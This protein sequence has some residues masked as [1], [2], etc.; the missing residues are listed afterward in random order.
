MFSWVN[1][2]GY[3]QG[4]FWA[5]LV[6]LVSSLNDVF[7][8][9]VGRLDGMQIAFMRFAISSLFLVPV[10]FIFNKSSFKTNRFGFHMVRA[11]FIYAAIVCW[12]MGVG[13]FSTPL[14]IASTLAQTTALFVLPMAFIFL[15]ERVS[16]QCS[17]ATIAGFIGIA[18]T[19]QPDSDMFSMSLFKDLNV[20]ALLLVG[21]AVLFAASD[22]FNKI[23]VDNESTLTMMFYI[24]AGAA[25]IGLYPAIQVWKELT[26]ME[27]GSIVALGIGANLILYCLLKAFAAT[28]ISNLM[29]YRYLELF[30]AGGFGYALFNEMPTTNIIIG[31]FIIV[32]S[33][34]TIG[35]YE[36]R[37]NNQ[38]PETN[39]NSEEVKQAA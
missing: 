39:G 18:I 17:I 3:A 37:K 14:S 35:W 1:K 36:S 8:R 32:I 27:W 24:A 28:K 23:M 33:T 22:I 12:C 15:K 6:C 25:L 30:F 10:M 2:K 7:I 5:V 16:W 26:L 9:N 11:I 21:A 19:V 31:S 4:V 38:S 34:F 20:G 29:P 13:V